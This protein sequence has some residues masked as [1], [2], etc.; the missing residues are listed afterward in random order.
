MRLAK[1]LAR[2]GVASRRRAEELIFEGRVA[3]NNKR[4]DKPQIQ[5]TETD[6]VT[7]DNKII[8]GPEEKVYLLINK[9]QGYIST[10][11][12]THGRP[13]VIQLVNEQDTR[14]YPVGRLDAD[15][16]GMLLLTN[17]GELANRLMHPRYG[18][19]KVYHALIYGLPGSEAMAKLKKGPVIDGKRR[20]PISA[21]LIKKDPGENTAILEIILAEGKKRQVKK[22]C[23]AI[24]HPVKKLS[25]VSFAGLN[26]GNL[27]E[28]SY[29]RLNTDEV[30]SLYA[31][32]N[33]NPHHCQR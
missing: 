17:D 25:R 14:L 30:K 21:K 8:E 31:L 16:S 22:M 13:T 3:V 7:L 19:K 10:A 15:T 2:A 4:V 9:P 11:K 27:K 20:T 5:V 6:R 32:V 33:L 24:G 26:T 1:F 23:R 28:G 29:R 18:V 12:D